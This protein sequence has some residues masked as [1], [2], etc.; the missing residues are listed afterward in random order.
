[1]VDAKQAAVKTYQHIDKSKVAIVFGREDKGLT[2]AELQQC[3]FHLSI[4]TS[5]YNSLNLSAAVQVVCYEI[6]QIYIENSNN[7]KVEKTRELAQQQQVQMLLQ[8]LE[9][10][11]LTLKFYKTRQDNELMARLKRLI[12]RAQ[13]DQV[14]TNILR[15]VLSSVDK[16]ILSNNRNKK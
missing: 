1:M 7:S 12:M 8:H 2:N 9:K 16:L 6:Y 10:T 4:P 13:L 15:G 5:K 14:E 3:H 11:L